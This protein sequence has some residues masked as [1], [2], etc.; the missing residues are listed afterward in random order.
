MAYRANQT[1]VSL[2]KLW[3]LK[4]LQT[5][6]F[7]PAPFFI[8]LLSKRLHSP[9]T[10]THN[11]WVMGA[12]T[13]CRKKK[14]HCQVISSNTATDFK[15]GLHRSVMTHSSRYCIDRHYHI[16]K[17]QEQGSPSKQEEEEEEEEYLSSVPWTK[18]KKTLQ[19]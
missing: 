2:E 12:S 19:E 15:R 5:P 3:D 11:S 16:V 6:F 7:L 4:I 10:Q 13:E 9:C 18:N 17:R 1:N 8:L 14:T